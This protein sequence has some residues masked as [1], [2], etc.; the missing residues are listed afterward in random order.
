[1]KDDNGLPGYLA[2]LPEEHRQRFERLGALV[3]ARTRELPAS[4]V[5]FVFLPNQDGHPEF[6]DAAV[7]F[8]RAVEELYLAS[9]RRD[10][11]IPLFYWGFHSYDLLARRSSNGVLVTDRA[12]YVR[13]VPSA[14]VAIAL[15]DLAADPVRF[16]GTVLSVGTADLDLKLAGRLLAETSAT[17]SVALLG[18]I[19]DD[20]RLAT[21]ADA[22]DLATASTT[23]ADRVTASTLAGDF[24]LPSRASDTKKLAKLSAKWKL[25]PD[26]KLLFAWVS[27]TFMGYYG[28]ALTDKA[29]WVKDLMDPLVRVDRADISPAGVDWVPAAKEFSLTPEHGVP[30]LPSVTDDNREYFVSLL[31]DLLALEG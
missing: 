31:R 4:V 3:D 18:G 26:E 16:A 29:A 9:P 15:A 22:S 10:Q 2:S 12:V 24:L 14:T 11:E 6:D 19:L 23:I 13:D 1:M 28:L 17:D 5:P 30:V 7:V 20:L 21:A 8:W 25:P 27:S